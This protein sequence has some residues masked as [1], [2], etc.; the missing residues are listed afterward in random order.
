MGAS[1]F[2]ES[3]SEL[4]TL[5]NTFSVAGTPT[6]PTTISLTVTSPSG[7]ATT[8]TYAGATITRTSAGVYTKDIACTEDGVWQ[9]VWTGTGT[10]SDVVAGTW[11]V[12]H[13]NLQRNYCSVEDLKSR[14]GLAS[15][16][17]TRDYELR[18]A[19]EAASRWVD[20]HCRQTFYR[21]TETRTF[22]T[23]DSYLLAVDPLVSITTLKTDSAGDGTFET[24]WTTSDYQL[25]PPNALTG[26]PRPY[27]LIRALGSYTFPTGGAYLDR[28]D[29]TQIVGVWGWPAV[30]APV[31]MASLIVAAELYKL[32]D[33]FSG[34]GGFGEFGP[35]A[36]R[37]NPQVI[38][39]LK[40]YRSNPVLVA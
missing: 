10:A 26:E 19:V 36:V 30:P 37:R 39:L 6:D 27:N 13:T 24:T 20:G 7:A 15:T 28:D 31:K 29:R 5:T 35:V 23:G 25:L 40:P 32:K 12:F 17:T 38:D 2:Y 18:D 33:T 14:F 9:Y 11:N 22:L 3:A 34:Q 4:A 1:V 8:Y 21:A 16:D